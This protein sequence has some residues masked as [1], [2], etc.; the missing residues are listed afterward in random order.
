MEFHPLANIFPL[1][2]DR[3]L[4]RLTDDIAAHG[5]LEP[6][7]V[8]EGK[9]LDG[10]NRFLALG[11]LNRE[12]RWEAWDDQ[13]DP[14]AFVIA[15]NVHRRHLGESQR[16]LAA[17]R[18]ATLCRGQ[19]ASRV[20]HPGAQDQAAQVP[21]TQGLRETPIGA[22]RNETPATITI[23]RA[24]DLFNVAP[25]SV[26]RARRVLE[27]GDAALVQI[28]EEG[29]VSVND[30]A[31]IATRPNNVQRAAVEA[32]RACKVRTVSSGAAKLERTPRPSRRKPDTSNPRPGPDARGTPGASEIDR[33]RVDDEAMA[34]V[35]RWH[36]ERHF[37]RLRETR[38]RVSE[39]NAVTCAIT[40]EQEVRSA[41]E[42]LD[43]VVHF[44]A[45]CLERPS[46]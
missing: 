37:E 2:P 45:D 16:A 8:Y 1:M 7:H 6:I 42:A 4:E 43:E 15:R 17:A 36:L 20:G 26:N 21:A 24:A 25:R 46:T 28:V 32:V 30:A 19:N 10:R 34:V 22:S 5:Q 11:R 35:S 12:P 3:E 9:I 14:L 40:L 38:W 23:D 41:V 27:R 44:I 13:C 31:K 29:I 33:T 18:L 39:L